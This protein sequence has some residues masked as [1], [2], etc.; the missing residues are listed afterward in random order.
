MKKIILT[1]A[2]LL[3][4]LT[5]CG[6]FS[7]RIDENSTEEYL[8]QVQLT[9]GSGKATVE[10]PAEVTCENGTYYVKLIWSS[11]N[12]DYMIVDGQKYDNEADANSNSVFTIPFEVFNEAFTVI[13]DTTAMSIPHE[14]EYELTIYS[15]D[16]DYVNDIQKSD[17][18]E[19]TDEGFDLG[20]LI[21]D[22]SL[23]LKY[24]NEFSIDYYNDNDNN[25]YAF[26]SIGEDGNYQYFLKPLDNAGDLNDI[27]EN[28]TVLQD[29]DKTYLVSTSVMDLINQIGALDNIL[30]SGT[31]ASDWYVEEAAEK[32]EAGE[33]Y[34]AGKYSAPDYE[35]LITDK[36]NFVIEN[37]MIYHNPEVKE[38]LEELGIPV[39]VE[40]S[41]YET[42]PLGRLEW[43]KLYGILYNKYNQAN[44]YFN[45][46][47]STVNDIDNLEST[48]E[49][50]AFFSVNSNGQITVRKSKD[51]VVSMIEMA[52]GDSIVWDTDEDNALSTMKITMEDFYLKAVDADILIYNSTIEGEI[53]NMDDLLKEASYL[54]DFK[55]VKNKKVFCLRKEYF[56]KSSNVAEFIE[57]LHSILVDDYDSL[58]YFYL[59]E[60]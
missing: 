23:K 30:F 34:Y 53:D 2:V 25:K 52:G 1:A 17:D 28:I 37:T 39:L 13:G 58:Q 8:C 24:A 36:C 59:L 40:R 27:S 4:S 48:N 26:I 56:Q 46:Q 19:S 20:N 12:Y 31:K 5:A 18:I 45:I 10:S 16:S 6:F 44:E 35:L 32:M 21:Y 41:S 33:I 54:S 47:E 55:A 43:I 51:Y 14:I 60:E 3:I 22:S 38:K 42:N 57:E 49:T 29:I 11:P 9:G 50:I 15:P 7:N